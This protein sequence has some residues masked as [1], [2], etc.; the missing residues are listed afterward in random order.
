M[1]LNKLEQEVVEGKLKNEK[2][3]LLAFA[4]EFLKKEMP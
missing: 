2:E 4:K 1:T 3:E